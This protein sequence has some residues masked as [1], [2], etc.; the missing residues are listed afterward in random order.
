MA[1][2]VAKMSVDDPGSPLP[3]QAAQQPQAGKGHERTVQP[4]GRSRE[5]E[6]AGA[7]DRDPFLHLEAGGGRAEMRP[8]SADK[9]LAG[10]PGNRSDHHQGQVAGHPKHPLPDEQPCPGL[11]GVGKQPGEHHHRG[12][13]LRT[14]PTIGQP[15]FH[16]HATAS[17]TRRAL[18]SQW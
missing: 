12:G 10:E 8:E 3:P 4:L 18:P 1:V 9:P 17:R 7:I 5:R 2:R 13:P 14:L 11:S 6:K 16:A 15:D